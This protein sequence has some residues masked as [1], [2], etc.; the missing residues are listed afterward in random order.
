VQ[1]RVFVL[2]ERRH[3]A[4]RV[5]SI[6]ATCVTRCVRLV[7]ISLEHCQGVICDVSEMRTSEVK[8]DDELDKALIENYGLLRAFV[9]CTDLSDDKMQSGKKG[10]TLGF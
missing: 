2:C 4:E 6:C 1:N 3:P 5:I 8:C 9:C 7:Q 10:H